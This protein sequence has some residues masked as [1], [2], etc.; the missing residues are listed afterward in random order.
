MHRVKVLTAFLHAGKP[1]NKL[2]CIADILEDNAFSLGGK[3]TMSDLIPFVLKNEKHCIRSEILGKAVSVIFDGTTRLGEAM[4][5]ILRYVDEDW[6]IQQCLVRFLRTVH[7]MT[8]EEV[9]RELLTVLSTELGITSQCLLVATQD[10]ASINNVAVRTLQ[11]MYPD[12]LDVG[13]FLHTLKNTGEHFNTSI[14]YD[15][16][17][18]NQAERADWLASM[19]ILRNMLVEQVGSD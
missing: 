3:R 4:C 19:L 18:K 5:I 2:S 1:P 11:V 10:R 17:I 7:S 9:A 16:G 13:C 14:L 15:P 6:K 12:A 8:G